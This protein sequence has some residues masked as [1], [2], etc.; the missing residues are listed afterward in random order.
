MLKLKLQYFGHQYF[1]CK[2]LTHWKSPWCWERLRAEGK[3]GVRG[4]GGW[5]ASLMQWTWTSVNSGRW[6]G[7]GR[8]GVLQFMGLQRVTWLGDWTT[9][10]KNYK[11]ILWTW[12][13]AQSCPTLCDPMDCSLPGSSDHGIFQA[14]V[15]EWVAIF[16][17]RGSSQP[18]YRTR[19]SS[20]TGRR[21]TVWAT[22]EALR[23][24]CCC[25]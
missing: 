1:G 12:E 20:S 16:F 11:E 9:I 5:M 19:V 22:R 4:W 23:R 10:R 8:P 6:W 25:C 7:T 18:R 14:R 21:F 17:S 2:Q 15:L 3:E 24:F 13:V